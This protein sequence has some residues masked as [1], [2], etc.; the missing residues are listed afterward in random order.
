MY[1]ETKI[2]QFK[3]PSIP[4]KWNALS[5]KAKYSNIHNVAKDMLAPGPNATN[6]QS[7]G[8]RALIKKCANRRNFIKH[9]VEY[10]KQLLDE[11]LPRDE[12]HW[13]LFWV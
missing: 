6:T 11:Q 7:V 13:K 1:N 4:L 9:K 5:R 12:A 3:F 10:D 8:H 2:P